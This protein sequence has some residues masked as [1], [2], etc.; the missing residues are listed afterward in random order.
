MTFAP[1]VAVDTIGTAGRLLVTPHTDES[2]I[3]DWFDAA[4]G[5]PAELHAKL[6]E[7]TAIAMVDALDQATRVLTCEHPERLDASDY[8]FEAYLGLNVE[9]L[10]DWDS[11]ILD[12]R[13]S[14]SLGREVTALAPDGAEVSFSADAEGDEIIAHFRVELPEKEL[15]RKHFA[16]TSTADW[17][18]IER[19]VPRDEWPEPMYVGQRGPNRRNPAPEVQAVIKAAEASRAESF[20]E[21]YRII[22]EWRHSEHLRSDWLHPD[23][24]IIED[25]TVRISTVIEDGHDDDDPDNYDDPPEWLADLCD[26]FKVDPEDENPVDTTEGAPFEDAEERLLRKAGLPSSIVIRVDGPW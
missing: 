7:E 10:E 11:S 21:S 9:Y 5:S 14:G 2:E 25:W 20:A 1:R 17:P 12:W 13:P 23:A 6:D 24:F 3:R 26:G 22:L 8:D 16:T 19:Y 15:G 4:Y 18:V